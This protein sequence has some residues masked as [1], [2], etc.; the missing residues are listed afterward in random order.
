MRANLTWNATE[1]KTSLTRLEEAIKATTPV[2]PAQLIHIADSANA[3]H[4]ELIKAAG[5]RLIGPAAARL[6]GA[7]KQIGDLAGL[8][9]ARLPAEADALRAPAL[10]LLKTAIN[11]VSAADSAMQG[12]LGFVNTALVALDKQRDAWKS[13]VQVLLG[14]FTQVQVLGDLQAAAKAWVAMLDIAAK[15][16]ILNAIAPALQHLQNEITARINGL[17]DALQPVAVQLRAVVAQATGLATKWLKQLNDEAE[18][19]IN[20][21]NCGPFDELAHDLGS[22]L[23]KA[24]QTIHEQV[25]GTLAAMADDTAR[26]LLTTLPEAA[27]A[28]GKGIKL[29]KAIGELPELPT[30]TFNA[31]RAEYLFDDIKKQIDTSPFAAKLREIDG[32]LKEL[33]LAIPTNALLDQLV[34][35]GL[36]GVDFGKVFKNLGGIDFQDF[37][38]RFKL[39]ELSSDKIKVTHGLDKETRSAWAKAA[40]NA[41]FPEEQTL[42]E[43]ASMAVRLSNIQ[44]RA[45]SDT[46]VTADGQS[47]SVTEGRLVSNWGL[48]FGG[49]RMAAFDDVTVKFDGSGF[50]FDISPD[51]VRLHPSLKFIEEY[52]KRF[53][54]N[55]PPAIQLERDDRGIPT[56]ARANF[57]TLIDKLPPLGPVTI[58]PLLLSSGMGLRMQKSG[59]FEVST[60]V[61]LGSKTAPVFV[62]FGYLGGGFWIEAHCTAQGSQV[63]PGASLGLALGSMRALNIAGV[64]RG[65]YALLLFANAEVGA[66]GG[67]LHAG[68]SI[69]GSARILGVANA[70]LDLL[71][72]VEHTSQGSRGHGWLHVEIEICWCYTLRVST[73]AEHKF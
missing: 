64:A 47:R 17:V 52:A 73:A 61:G 48:D 24:E 8:L 58:G 59:V 26:H 9:H 19:V 7:A 40:V 68:L 45:T 10:E 41:N 28:I 43:C 1:A 62:Q 11:L 53:Q 38:K 25:S 22:A 21:F 29:A 72:E 57:S 70:S 3:A 35:D 12:V 56:G 13:R 31:A 27:N 20:Q 39:P 42:F 63:I 37:F 23:K 44:L 14:T 55:L 36:Q 34:P 60:F 5:Q 6:A 33:G 65:S 32:G 18:A 66:G 54:D 67:S 2:T 50:D 69:Q 16:L 15:D 46:R 49:T 51:K 4:A 71:L 30:L